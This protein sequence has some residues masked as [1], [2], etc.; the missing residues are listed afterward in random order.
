MHWILL[1]F[2]RC[3]DYSGRSRRR[4]YWSY[5]PLALLALMCIPGTP[6][7]N[8]FGP[9]PKSRDLAGTFD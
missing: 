5:A 2:R 6:G 1:P 8:R 7:P 9:D 4:E 3:L